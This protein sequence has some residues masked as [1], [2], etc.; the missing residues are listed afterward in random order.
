MIDAMPYAIRLP[1]PGC[2]Q[3]ER[4][5]SGRDLLDALD[6][7]LADDSASADWAHVHDWTDADSESSGR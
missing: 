2:G 1:Q 5:S 3:R 6:A 4:T 7:W